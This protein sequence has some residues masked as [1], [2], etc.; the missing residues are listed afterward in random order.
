MGPGRARARG[1]SRK[2]CRQH[3]VRGAISRADGALVRGARLYV[4]R[5]EVDAP[6]RLPRDL[7]RRRR[8]DHLALLVDGRAVGPARLGI[9]HAVSPAIEVDGGDVAVEVEVAAG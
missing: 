2:G 6:D 3:L 7:P 8:A 5:A 9:D 1:M 4:L